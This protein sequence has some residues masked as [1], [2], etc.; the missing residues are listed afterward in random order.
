VA[1]G[2][3]TACALTTVVADLRGDTVGCGTVAAGGETA[4]ALT[5]VVAGVWRSSAA[6]AGASVTAAG[7]CALCG[8]G[9]KMAA[10]VEDEAA[11]NLAAPPPA[12]PAGPPTV[13]AVM[14]VTAA[15]STAGARNGGVHTLLL[16]AVP[17]GSPGAANVW[18]LDGVSDTGVWSFESARWV[19]VVESSARLE[20]FMDCSGAAGLELLMR[21]SPC[22]QP[23]RLRL[24]GVAAGVVAA[25]G[26]PYGVGFSSL[27]TL[28]ETARFSASRSF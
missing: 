11:L 16:T 15:T 14:A 24:P 7:A 13:A 28:T 26:E 1:A 23:S 8:R 20:L 25:I 3:D 12:S 21:A 18:L 19:G 9:A 4:C 5:T 27:R 2:G 17:S 22:P 10:T 6:S